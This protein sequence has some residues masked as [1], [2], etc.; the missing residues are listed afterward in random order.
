MDNGNITEGEVSASVAYSNVAVAA[1]DVVNEVEVPPSDGFHAIDNVKST[2]TDDVKPHIKIRQSRGRKQQLKKQKK[3]ENKKKNVSTM[4]TLK[5]KKKE[6]QQLHEAH[7][8]K[9][10]KVKKEKDGPY[11]KNEVFQGFI[12]L[13]THIYITHG[14]KAFSIVLGGGPS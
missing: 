13:P 2:S 8:K 1:V 9:A 10:A 3:V 5:E 14:N 11:T 4:K 7:K 6:V 12:F